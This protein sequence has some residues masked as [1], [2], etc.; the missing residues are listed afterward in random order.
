MMR[1]RYL[2]TVGKCQEETLRNLY[3]QAVQARSLEKCIK[4]MRLGE[5]ASFTVH[6][7]VN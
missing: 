4:T 1:R 5:V 2:R 3:G 7:S 6:E